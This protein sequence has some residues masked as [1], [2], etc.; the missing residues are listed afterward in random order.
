MIWLHFLLSSLVFSIVDIRHHKVRKVHLILAI[1]TL[2]PGLDLGSIVNATINYL[3][4]RFLY[5]ISRKG[6]GYGDVR[7]AFLIGLYSSSFFQ[8]LISLVWINAYTWSIAGVFALIRL[9]MKKMGLH[10]RI[11]FAPFMF[12]GVLATAMIMK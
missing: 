6:I 7:L 12:L 1:T 4:Y 10:D 5:E 8:T 11:A 2:L 9:K 3:G